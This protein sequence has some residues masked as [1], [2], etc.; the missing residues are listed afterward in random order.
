M[1]LKGLITSQILVLAFQR[2]DDFGVYDQTSPEAHLMRT[3]SN[4]VTIM[5]P[6]ALFDAHDS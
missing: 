5:N 3:G 6:M 4:A 2:L 1:S